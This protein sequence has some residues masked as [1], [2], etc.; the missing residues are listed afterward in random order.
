MHQHAYLQADAALRERR[1]QTHH[2][3]HLHALL[4]TRRSDRSLRQD[5]ADLLVRLAR[6]V[7]PGRAGADR[8]G[9]V[10]PAAPV[11]CIAC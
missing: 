9:A 5:V 7:E 1:L 2:H 4:G 8:A 10:R 11:P 6:V 3:V